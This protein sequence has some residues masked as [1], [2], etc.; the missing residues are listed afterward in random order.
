MVSVCVLRSD[1]EVLKGRKEE[2][3]KGCGLRSLEEG[4]GEG[5]EGY[6]LR[7]LSTA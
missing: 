4:R 7:S 3:R 5:R 1:T 2:G 6:G